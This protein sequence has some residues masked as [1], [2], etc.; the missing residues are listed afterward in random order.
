MTPPFDEFVLFLTITAVLGAI[1]LRLRQPS[2][3]ACSAVGILLGPTGFTR[4]SAP[5]LA[6]KTKEPSA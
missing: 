6:E 4:V 1:A 3:I 2:P 5:K